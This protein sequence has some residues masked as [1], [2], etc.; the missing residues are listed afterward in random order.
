MTSSAIHQ[1]NFT[2]N[3]STRALKK[4]SLCFA[5]QRKKYVEFKI[6]LRLSNVQVGLGMKCLE[7]LAFYVLPDLKVLDLHNAMESQP[8]LFAD[9]TCLFVTDSNIGVARIFDWG[10][11]K[12]QI[13]CY[14]VIRNFERGIFVGAKIS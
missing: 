2:Y 4:A 11:P 13:T 6:S 10:G 3:K 5:P 12:P 14:D 8:R 9:D 7:T 1:Y